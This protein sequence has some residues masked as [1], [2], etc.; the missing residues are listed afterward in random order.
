M[1]HH[2]NTGNRTLS[3]EPLLPGQCIDCGGFIPCECDRTDALVE[4]AREVAASF[5]DPT[6]AQGTIDLIL[7]G[8]QDKHIWV[9]VAA[10]ALE[11]NQRLIVEMR[12]ALKFY[13]NPEVYRPHPHG[14]AFD[15]RDLSFVARKVLAAVEA[16]LE[17]EK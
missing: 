11:A 7:A 10:A 13:A 5:L 3:G 6:I 12:E 17:D 16:P 9:R 1:A 15:N 2:P 14:P 4:R 8:K